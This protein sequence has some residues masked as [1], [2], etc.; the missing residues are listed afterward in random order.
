MFFFLSREQNKSTHNACDEHE[1]E[2]YS[3]G[4]HE[5]SWSNLKRIDLREMQTREDQ[6]ESPA[7]A[8]SRHRGSLPQA[9]IRDPTR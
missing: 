4:R 1:G 2:I 6:G 8:E 9:Q 3:T 7:D 5:P